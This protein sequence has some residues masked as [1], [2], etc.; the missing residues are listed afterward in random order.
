MSETLTADAVPVVKDPLRLTAGPDTPGWAAEEETMKKDVNGM[1]G[2]DG[3]V[4]SAYLEPSTLQWPGDKANQPGG[5]GDKARSDVK[6]D[7][8]ETDAAAEEVSVQSDFP[9]G[10]GGVSRTESEREFGEKDQ[11]ELK[12]KGGHLEIEVEDLNS[13]PE[14]AAGVFSPSVTILRSTSM[15]EPPKQ[16]MNWE[17][18][19][20]KSPFLGRQVTLP[21]DCYHEYTKNNSDCCK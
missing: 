3:V 2:T 8:S 14:K 12:E 1:E 18:S 17:A 20:E 15:P 19:T 10:H 21:D 9:M 13:M 6:L 5:M 4:S 11:L 7:S 16:S